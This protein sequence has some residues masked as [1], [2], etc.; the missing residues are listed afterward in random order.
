[1]SRKHVMSGAAALA[2]IIAFGAVAAPVAHAATPDVVIHPADLNTTD[3]RAA[4][5]VSFRTDGLN[6]MDRRR[7]EPGEGGRLLRR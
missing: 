4:G 2:A 3:T 5:H 1:M 6:V 7:H